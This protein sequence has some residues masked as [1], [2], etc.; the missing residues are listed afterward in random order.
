M[1]DCYNC[2]Y[3]Y[4]YYPD[5]GAVDVVCQHDDNIYQKQCPLPDDGE[6]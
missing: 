3:G 5:I 4:V 1:T 2:E 6:D